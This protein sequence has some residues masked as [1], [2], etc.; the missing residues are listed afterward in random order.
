MIYVLLTPT[1]T[2]EAEVRTTAYSNSLHATGVVKGYQA[3][4]RDM[5]RQGRKHSIIRSQAFTGYKE[6]PWSIR[7]ND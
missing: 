7:V 4:S 3:T 1:N 6:T 2:S 5:Q